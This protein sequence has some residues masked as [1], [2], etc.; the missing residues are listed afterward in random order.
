MVLQHIKNF[1][2]ALASYS[3][4]YGF[5]K[6]H[7]LNYYY[8][9]PIIFIVVVIS[10]GWQGTTAVTNHLI[11]M[12][13]DAVDAA[14][15]TFDRAGFLIGAIKVVVWITLRIFFFLIISYL[16]GYFIL[17]L[18]S[19][20]FSSI[21][22]RTMAILDSGA[23]AENRSS[24]IGSAL[25]GMVLAVRNLLVEL[26]LTIILL[27]AGFIPVIGSVSPFLAVGVTSYFYGF[28]FIDYAVEQRNLN[29]SQS[30]RLMR[31]HRAEVLGIGLPFTLLL[32]IPFIGPYLAV[33][34]SVQATVAATITAHRAILR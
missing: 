8:L 23:V 1:K 31:N 20:V 21:S 34:V 33:F 17:I 3:E 13:T 26:G 27:I 11:G 24:L 19:P 5:I 30:I 4:G 25:R 29:I 14:G 12:I 22:N 28:S 2:N 10:A 32:S 16:G 9:F 15:W 6:K 18:M 7:R